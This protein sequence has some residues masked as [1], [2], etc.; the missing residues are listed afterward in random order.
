MKYEVVWASFTSKLIPMQVGI[1][2]LWSS[3]ERHQCKHRTGQP[4]Y[5]HVQAAWVCARIRPINTRN[6]DFS[7]GLLFAL[8]CRW[9]I[10]LLFTMHRQT[11]N[12]FC[13]ETLVQKKARVYAA[14]YLIF[15]SAIWYSDQKGVDMMCLATNAWIQYPTASCSHRSFIAWWLLVC[16]WRVHRTLLLYMHA[17]V[18]ATANSRLLQTRTGCHHLWSVWRLACVVISWVSNISPFL[19]GPAREIENLYIVNGQCIRPTS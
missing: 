11:L 4:R 13:S 8:I 16:S 10:N 17:S 9:W 1:D 2:I 5:Q 19:F 15:W 14:S 6:T 3:Y 18:A 7:R 12:D